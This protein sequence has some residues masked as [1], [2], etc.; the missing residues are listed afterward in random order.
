MRV[1]IDRECCIGCGL[2]AITAPDVF[3]MDDAG[4]AVVVS[5]TNGENRT[6]VV[7]AMDGCPVSAICERK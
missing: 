4:K 3:E 7:N 1:Y 6:A 2:C 5:D